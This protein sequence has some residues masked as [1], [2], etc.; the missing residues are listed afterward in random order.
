VRVAVFG[1]FGPPKE[2][3]TEQNGGNSRPR[4]AFISGPEGPRKG[5]TGPPKGPKGPKR[6]G[7]R[8]KRTPGGPE[9]ALLGPQGLGALKGPKPGR[10]RPGSPGFSTFLAPF[11]GPPARQKGPKTSRNQGSQ[12]GPGPVSALLGPQARKRGGKVVHLGPEGPQVSHRTACFPGPKGAG[13]RGPKR[14][15]EAPKRPCCKA[16]NRAAAAGGPR[17]GPKK[18]ENRK[19][20]T[21]QG[22]VRAKRGRDRP[23]GPEKARKHPN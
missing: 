22:P 8:P 4:S 19:N 9:W 5:H 2:A 21:R 3:E 16:Q 7:K 14:A 1:P 13:E 15:P 6:A 20:R 12:A 11:G 23:E 18:G 17:K 10:G